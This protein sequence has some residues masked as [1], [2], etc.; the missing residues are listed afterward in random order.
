MAPELFRTHGLTLTE[1]VLAK[2]QTQGQGW[3]NTAAL[4]D[5]DTKHFHVFVRVLDRGPGLSSCIALIGVAP[6]NADLSEEDIE[7]TCGAFVRLPFINAL[8]KDCCHTYDANPKGES[9]VSVR[10]CLPGCVHFKSEGV[11]SQLGSGLHMWYNEGRLSFAFEGYPHISFDCRHQG[12]EL[13]PCIAIGDNGVKLL[14]SVDSGNIQCPVPPE[15]AIESSAKLRKTLWNDRVFTDAQVVCGDRSFAVHRCVLAAASPFFATA[16]GSEMQEGREAKVIIGDA[17]HKCVGTVLRY[18]YT[19]TISGDVD[20]IALL[21]IAHRFDIAAL[22]ERCAADIASNVDETNV[23]ESVASLRSLSSNSV[24]NVYWK[25]LLARL[26]QNIDLLE[27]SYGTC[28]GSP[29][30]QAL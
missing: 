28:T 25:S 1:G 8:P 18:L 15:G 19:G 11:Q 26:S 30:E 21:P 13:Y 6:C 4:L 12:D 22:I 23:A 5:V 9:H 10:F 29:P 20:S 16:F 14:V 27:R 2:T 17:S 3:W 7:E 24:V